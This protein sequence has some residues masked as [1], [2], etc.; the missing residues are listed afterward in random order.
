MLRIAGSPN[1]E[2]ADTLADL[3]QSPVAEDLGA[4]PDDAELTVCLRA[5]RDAAPG[6]DEVTAGMLRCASPLVL[7]ELWKTV[8]VMWAHPQDDR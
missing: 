6:K 1:E 4:P 2:L 3:P 5:M 8:R 7:Q